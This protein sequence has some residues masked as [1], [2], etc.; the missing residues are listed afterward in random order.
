MRK[1]FAVCLLVACGRSTEPTTDVE[2]GRVLFHDPELSEPAGQACADC[3]DDS[4][5]FSDPE[6]DRSS[7][8]VIRERVGYRNAQTA[9]YAGFVPPLTR[10]GDGYIGGLFWDGR[11]SS[12]EAQAAGPLLNPLEMNNPSM[13]RV[14]EKVRRK[15]GRALRRLFGA[16]ALDRDDEVFAHVGEVIAA[17]QRTA[18]FAPFSSR[19]DRF[20]A[21]SAVLGDQELR[22]LAVFEDPARGNCA[23]CHPSRPVGD[24]PALF[25]T[26]GYANLGLPKWD[27]SMFYLLPPSLNPDGRDFVDH[28]L[29]TTVHDPAFDGMFRIPTLRNVA[30]TAPYGHNGYF[31]GLREFVQFINARDVTCTTGT[32]RAC[33]TAEVPATVDHVHTGHL[34]L[35]AGE[36]DDVIAFLATLDDSPL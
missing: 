35:D 23:S 19:Y 29:M 12:L 1:W 6:D 34:G 30:R 2:L 18:V 33:P 14:A 8:G 28:G 13:Q 10:T 17:Y 4:T 36:I 11:A 16:H 21:G 26:Y 25:T 7:A 32:P 24:R 15:Y 22:G 5:A 3:H 9:M 31:R 27:N 20:L